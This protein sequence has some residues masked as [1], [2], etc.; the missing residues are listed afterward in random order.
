M[1]RSPQGHEAIVVSGE[2]KITLAR[3]L[4]TLP[5]QIKR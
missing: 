3:P 2:L 4:A 5:H 1:V